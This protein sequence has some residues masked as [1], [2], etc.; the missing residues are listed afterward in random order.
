[1]RN[2]LMGIIFL[3][4]VMFPMGCSDQTTGPVDS[5]SQSFFQEEDIFFSDGF[6]P[7]KDE[8]IKAKFQTILTG[9]DEV[10]PRTTPA[11][12][13]AKFKLDKK[14]TRIKYEI[15]VDSITNVVGAHIHLGA[16]G[17]NGPIVVGLYSAASAGG[18]LHGKLVKGFFTPADLTGPLAGS[19]S[20]DS[21]LAK[22]KKDSLYV[23]VHTDDGAA[24]H[25]TGPGDFPGGEIR[26]QL[27]GKKHPKH[28]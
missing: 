26:G 7:P 25:D 10:P 13:F 17:I 5:S 27:V 18:P 8:K 11:R 21:L 4:I 1:M 22:L 19:V 3:F 28:P 15:K 12:G 6:K 14:G 9:A 16:V 20:F 2:A 24:P 23:N